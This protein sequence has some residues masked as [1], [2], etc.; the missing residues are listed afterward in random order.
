MSKT[1]LSLIRIKLINRSASV[2]IF[3]LKSVSSI[4]FKFIFTFRYAPSPHARAIK[5]ATPASLAALLR[6]VAAGDLTT[7][8]GRDVLARMLE[9]NESLETATAA[10]GIERVDQSELETLC[11]E[12]LDANPQ[13]V[14]D[15][16]QGKLKAAGALIGQA[17]RRNPNVNPARVQEICLELIQSSDP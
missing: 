6:Q 1:F 16:K 2:N 13:I 15:V 11:R 5:A 12:L 17:K 14:E 3:P 9:A 7:S 4:P 8:R 10:L